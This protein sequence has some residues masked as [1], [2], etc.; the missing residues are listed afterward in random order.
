MF[1]LFSDNLAV[2]LH[3]LTLQDK[4]NIRTL[5]LNIKLF[6]T[7]CEQARKARQGLPFLPVSNGR[8][9]KCYIFRQCTYIVYVIRSLINMLSTEVK[10]N[11]ISLLLLVSVLSAILVPTGSWIF[12]MHYGCLLLNDEFDNFVLKF[13]EFV[14]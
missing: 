4:H 9:N 7:R 13:N 11:F 2:V 6:W 10:L 14:Y 8:T 5:S 1:Q 3:L 12:T